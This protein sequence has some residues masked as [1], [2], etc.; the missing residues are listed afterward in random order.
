MTE[1]R[2][3]ALKSIH[4][5]GTDDEIIKTGGC[6]GGEVTSFDVHFDGQISDRFDTDTASASVNQIVS[7]KTVTTKSL[8]TDVSLQIGVEKPI[9]VIQR[10]EGAVGD[11]VIRVEIAAAALFVEV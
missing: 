4:E 9:L 10:A 5:P 11:I 6:P 1:E 8:I 7:R 2:G 3:V